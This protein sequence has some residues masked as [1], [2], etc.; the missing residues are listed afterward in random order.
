MAGTVVGLG[1]GLIGMYALSGIF[2]TGAGGLVGAVGCGITV[3]YLSEKRLSELVWD[4][5]IADMVSSIVFFVLVLVGYI[6]M[7]GV[8][9]GLAVISVVWFSVLYL[10]FGGLMAVSIGAVS[11]I[12]TAVSATVTA[13]IMQRIGN[14][15]ALE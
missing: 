3:A 1:T 14:R 4:A 12:I 5:V 2:P 13:L 11:L 8:T 7:V 6:A 10:V 9:E 15:P